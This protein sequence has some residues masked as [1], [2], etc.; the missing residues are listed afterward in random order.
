[1][2]DDLN[3]IA[4]TLIILIAA[5]AVWW[6]SWS[7]GW[8]LKSCLLWGVIIQFVV[9]YFAVAA[10]ARRWE[11]PIIQRTNLEFA[12]DEGDWQWCLFAANIVLAA[13]GLGYLSVKRVVLS[14][15]PAIQ[16]SPLVRIDGTKVLG[17]FA[18]IVVS[19]LVWAVGISLTHGLREHFANP[20]ARRGGA[21]AGEAAGFLIILGGLATT[22]AC[23]CVAGIG[24]MA[25]GESGRVR[26]ALLVASGLVMAGPVLF[27]FGG[28]GAV[29]GFF[30]VGLVSMYAARGRR[31][32]LAI[33]SMLGSFA[34]LFAVFGHTVFTYDAWSSGIVS[35][36]TEALEHYMAQVEVPLQKLVTFGQSVI[37]PILIRDAMESGLPPHWFRDVPELPLYFLPKL[38]HGVQ[39]YPLQVEMMDLFPDPGANNNIKIVA[40][41]W[42]GGGWSGLIGG[43]L[44]CGGFLAVVDQWIARA[45][46]H[47]ALTGPSIVLALELGVGLFNGGPAAMRA[48]LPALLVLLML[49]LILADQVRPSVG[50]SGTRVASD[51]TPSRGLGPSES[52]S[53][54]R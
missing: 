44:V 24:A 14:N 15:S 25:W 13:I 35:S 22:S 48:S 5:Q 4:D 21:D 41:L 17:V 1:M 34:V 27:S 51:A 2:I 36:L 3:V 18:V 23:L 29:I 28:R 43:G 53:V 30:G 50:L 32:P 33:W 12:L 20:L 26:A 31:V 19:Y 6:L 52:T 47:P 45:S 40:Y 46:V 37:H 7:R 38:V 9:P 10:I 8:S 39:Y 49:K 54:T 16:S 11:L 42:W